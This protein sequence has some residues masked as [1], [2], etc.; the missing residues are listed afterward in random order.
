MKF[1]I[2]LIVLLLS[3]TTIAQNNNQNFMQGLN[4]SISENFNMKMARNIG[5]EEGKVRII[6]S[7]RVDSLGVFKVKAKA[8]HEKLE[9]EAV[10]V[11]NEYYIKNKEKLKENGIGMCYNLPIQFMIEK[12]DN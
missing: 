4:K 1:N 6:V 8:P 9:I 2:I 3:L 10:R 12:K 5:L 11:V 7:M